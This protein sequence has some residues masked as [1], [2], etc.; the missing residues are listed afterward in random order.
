MGKGVDDGVLETLFNEIDEVDSVFVEFGAGQ[1]LECVT[2]YLREERAWKG[3]LFDP[4]FE[5]QEMFLAKET[6]RPSTILDIM[7]KYKVHAH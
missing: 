5:D 6:P 7:E 2:R 3:Q 1:G 4:D